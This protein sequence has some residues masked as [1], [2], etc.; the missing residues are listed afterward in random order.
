MLLTNVAANLSTEPDGLFF[1][2]ETVRSGRLRLV[3]REGLGIMELE[4]SADVA[5]EVVSKTSVRKDTVLLRELYWKAGITEYWLVD[6]REGMMSFEILQWTRE[7]YVSVPPDDGW[8]RSK[9]L[10]K[11]FRLQKKTDPLGHAQFVVEA[12]D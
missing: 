4:G 5:L 3:E 8:I 9:V 11:K 1:A 12:A 6:V 2:W 7:G 10:G